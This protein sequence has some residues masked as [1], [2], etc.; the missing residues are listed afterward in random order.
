MKQTALVEV[1]PEKCINCHRCISE[2]PVKFC[3]EGRGDYVNVNPDRCIGCGRCIHVCTHGARIPCDDF[4][5]FI[6]D[7]EKGTKIIAIV[8]PSVAA[9]FPGQERHLNGWL[10]HMGID[11]LFDVSFGAELAARSY[12]DL[13][14]SGNGRTLISQACPTIVSY[15]QNHKPGLIPYLAP[16][17]SPMLHLMKMIRHHHTE[18][19]D[20]RIAAI[21]PC[22]SK[23][24]EFEETELGDYNVTY[25]S[26]KSYLDRHHIDL[27]DFAP[28]PYRNPPPERA[29]LFSTPGGLMRTAERWL[30]E[31]AG[32]TRKIEGEHAVYAYLDRLEQTLHEEQSGLPLLV[33]CLNCQYGCNSGPGA[34]TEDA[35]PDIIEQ[36]IESRSAAGQASI[37][38]DAIN[39]SIEHYWDK[40]LF[41]RNYINRSKQ[42]AISLPTPEEQK[43]ILSRMHKH[44]ELDIYNC[45]A[46]GYDRCEIMVTAIHNGLNKIENC[47]H[48]LIAEHKKDQQAIVQNEQRLSSILHTSLEGFVQLDLQGRLV[49]VNKTAIDMLGR[50]RHELIGM[51]MKTLLEHDSATTL[52]NQY[53]LRKQG[54]TSR[55]EI[56]LMKPDGSNR[57]CLWHGSPL[58]NPDHTPAGSFAMI[59]DITDFRKAQQELAIHRD[60]LEEL[61]QARTHSL[62]IEIE[63]RKDAEQT[64]RII[65]DRTPLA[66]LMVDCETR[67]IVEANA[68]ALDIIGHEREEIIGCSCQS[69]CPAGEKGCPVLDCGLKVENEDRLLLRKGNSP[70]P[71]LK[72]VVPI[73]H[74]GRNCLIE[75]IVDISKQKKLQSKL[76]EAK[77][78]AETNSQAKSEFLANM[79]H[80]IRTPMNGLLGLT[81]LA[82]KTDLSPQQHGYLSKIRTS[83]ESLLKI[84]NSILDF[85]KVEAGQIELEHIPFD[86]SRITR[87]LHDLFDHKTRDKGLELHIELSPDIPATLQGDPLR[88]QQV[89]VNLID[90]AVKFSD[91]GDILIQIKTTAINAEQTA[92]SFSVQ[93]TGIG[94]PQEQMNRIFEAFKQAD[95]STT[96]RFGGTGL[97]LSICQH[98]IRL[99][100]S[101]I[102][103]ESSPG[104]G[105]NFSFEVRFER[106]AESEE[107]RYRLSKRPHL[108]ILLA[109]E[110]DAIYSLLTRLAQYDIK[111]QKAGSIEEILAHLQQ[112]LSYEPFQ[113]IML[114]SRYISGDPSELLHF[115]EALPH[116]PRIML[117]GQPHEEKDH[118]MCSPIIDSML[119]RTATLSDLNDSISS[120]FDQ[121]ENHHAFT[122]P[123]LRGK[124]LLLVEDN[125]IN[126]EV[127]QGV[128]EAT[129]CQTSV[130]KNGAEAVQALKHHTFDLVLMDVQMPVMDGHKATRLIRQHEALS[131]GTRTPILAMTA[132]A[133]N[134]DKDL[135]LKA[136]MDAH[137]SKPIE[138]ETLYTTICHWL[139][140]P[141]IKLN[142]ENA[143]RLLAG[144]KLLYHKLLQKFV[145]D[146]SDAAQI[147]AALIADKDHEH[148]QRQAHTIKGVS[149]YLGA[150]ELQQASR[151]LETAIQKRAD[152]ER[153]FAIF[154]DAMSGSLSAINRE[155]RRKDDE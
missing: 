114:N 125:E 103:I 86:L 113:L 112:A 67:T 75:S 22:L 50:P 119:P 54:K 89:L 95:G 106:P 34:L 117:L 94:I 87:Q 6:T 36:H 105:S 101:E 155:L 10:K 144:K 149:G 150:T 1:D 111:I 62:K 71:I 61:V 51:R 52:S 49:D 44:S 32:K 124:H 102:Q 5:R 131:G 47:H 93:D 20:H 59:T 129:G 69:I 33:D 78:I 19:R 109:D 14:Q 24:R 108:R 46:C 55:Y 152:I 100:G 73:R 66:I 3:N 23:K 92:L 9:N 127:A 116:P 84:I 39:Q 64:L 122:V 16:I 76:Q 72:T 38:L 30:P 53:A 130:V 104:A 60:H 107:D 58:F 136:G 143:I 8:A 147:I 110:D 133:L 41:R 7:L 148:A 85:S 153:T 140:Q 90:N 142:T 135:A 63:N 132:G 27:T 154:S 137:I 12:V 40:S 82:L 4:S 151:A 123:D 25:R 11:V 134:E 138:P 79:S 81:Y 74:Q 31:L 88:L 115:L 17:D 121:T 98:L 18:Y 126:Q 43:L 13:I 48:Y 57:H 77:D 65:F 91:S 2:C 146:H 120:L 141:C 118:Q 28:E 56:S 37:D 35:S 45:S 26:L 97:G 145:D 128:L 96:R 83:S 68:V 42:S 99:M 21:S 29:V 80:E 15:I 70:L 139:N